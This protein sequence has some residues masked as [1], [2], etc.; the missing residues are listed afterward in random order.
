MLAMA[1]YFA[2]PLFSVTWYYVALAVVLFAFA[3]YLIAILRHVVHRPQRFSLLA[4]AAVIASSGIWHA[5][6][7]RVLPV[8]MR[9]YKQTNYSHGSKYAQNKS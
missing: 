5:C 4:L 2:R 6:Q 1:L 3:A 7:I 9:R 8:S